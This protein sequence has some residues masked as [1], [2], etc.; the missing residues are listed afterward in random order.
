LYELA[1]AAEDLEMEES[2]NE[3]DENNDTSKVKP[4]TKAVKNRDPTKPKNETKTDLTVDEKNMFG[5]VLDKLRNSA[6][7]T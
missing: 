5:V 1:C 4:I 7:E 6:R 2:D 3:G